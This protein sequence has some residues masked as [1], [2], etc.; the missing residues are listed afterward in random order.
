RPGH[1]WTSEVPR[2]AAARIMTGGLL[3][4]GT[5]TV[6]PV[7]ETDRESEE[8]GSVRISAQQ[9]ETSTLERGR[10]VRPAGEE[11]RE[12]AVLAGPGDTVTPG[13]LALLAHVGT[14]TVPVHRAPT[15]GLV[16]TGDEL[17]DPGNP[18][19]MDGGVRRVDILSPV[20]PALVRQAAGRPLAPRR[21]GDRV[22]EL[23]R[24]FREVVEASDLIITTGGASMGETDLVK[25]T[26]DGL[27]FELDFWRA[28]I[29]PG[30]PVSLGRLP[31]PG[32]GGKVPVIGLPGNPVSA[33]TTFHVFA[34]PSIR[35][36]GGHTRCS[37][38]N[39]R[40]TARDRLG[41]PK[42]LTR[43]FRVRL[44]PE[45]DGAW[46]ATLTG[47]QGSGVIQ[48]LAHADALA[49]V[50]EGVDGIDPGESVPVLLLPDSGWLRNT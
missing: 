5:D 26:L 37:L 14:G 19:E 50:P 32:A 41:G 9:G 13:L 35:H 12:G 28:R 4:P 7:E 42:R 39:L 23:D 6:V 29:R 43:F 11:V 27:G 24:A 18:D 25:R 36:L 46:G 44:E 3:P 38:P 16:V 31:R 33:V 49:M 22:D 1:P 45:G 20:L 2:G 47:R 17:V 40:A 21:V 8:P 30:S 10:Y 15:I 34:A 48:S